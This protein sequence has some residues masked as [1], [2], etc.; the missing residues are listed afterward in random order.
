M[1]QGIGPIG[2][3]HSH[4]FSSKIFH[5]HTDDSTLISLSKQFSNSTSIVTNG[6][7]IN[8]YRIGKN[9]KAKEISAEFSSPKMI[10]FFNISFNEVFQ[11]KIDNNIL[12]SKEDRKQ[13][14]V[15]LFNIL[16]TYL[17]K[18]WDELEYFDYGK[19]VVKNTNIKPYLTRNISS[20]SIRIRIPERFKEISGVKLQLN[21]E[22]EG[23][24]NYSQFK[25]KVK[26][27]IPIYSANESETLSN[28]NNMIK[29]ELLSNNIIQKIY[30]CVID[31]TKGRI[32]LPDDRY[33]NFFGYFIRLSSYNQ[34]ILNR[35]K[36]SSKN[37][38]IIMKLVSL[39][40]NFKKMKLNYTMK[41]HLLLSIS[42]I[43]KFSKKFEWE[44]SINKEINKL[45]KYFN[46]I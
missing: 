28:F 1:P 4:P 41:R 44:D 33:L 18:I 45:K 29:T 9:E 10:K 17:D 3:Y 36:L 20:K 42:D 8:Y 26:V 43:K 6:K 7:E 14:N 31:D 35:N 39:F 32:I 5:S 16:S 2:I 22:R 15:K 12:K 38:Q 24:N 30:N 21:K 11:L 40:E 34:Q 25:L 46:F 13:L 37:F 23:N 27:K 19:S